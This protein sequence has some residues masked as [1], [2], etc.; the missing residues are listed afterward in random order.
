MLGSLTEW[1]RGGEGQLVQPARAER[2]GAQDVHTVL[3]AA[4]VVHEP[5]LLGLRAAG[6]LAYADGGHGAKLAQRAARC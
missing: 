5:A 6:V 4:G 3:A 1:W 2:G